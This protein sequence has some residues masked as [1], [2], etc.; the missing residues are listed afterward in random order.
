MA[1]IQEETQGTNST[2]QVYGMVRYFL[3]FQC[4]MFQFL[5]FLRIS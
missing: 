5:D 3:N 2:Q 1:K 4:G